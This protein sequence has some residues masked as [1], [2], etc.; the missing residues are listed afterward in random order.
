MS[1]KDEMKSLTIKDPFWFEVPEI[2]YQRDRLNE[3]LPKS[4]MTDHEKLNALTRL[5]IYLGILF[6][7][8]NSNIIYMYIT[9]FGVLFTV[10]LYRN[11][12]Q[13]SKF[14]D[15][16][17]GGHENGKYNQ[18]M[19]GSGV[20]I[21]ST[22]ENPFMNILLTD[23]VDDPNRPPAGD[24]TDDQVKKEVEKNFNHNLYKDVDDIW[25]KNNS[26]RQYYTNPN[27]TIPNDRDSL[28]KWL[29]GNMAC[30]KDGNMSACLR[31]ETPLQHGQII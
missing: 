18:D 12:K 3:F 16:V 9:L 20:S 22:K 14:T 28:A 26:Q 19:Y 2:L 21:K 23:Y 25:D 10:F 7:V 31:Y 8:L 15:K 24:I 17:Y 5:F 11:L 6:S 27:T 29:Y 1:L 13:V 30:C 4:D